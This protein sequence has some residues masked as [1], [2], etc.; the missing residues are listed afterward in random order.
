MLRTL[1]SCPVL[2]VFSPNSPGL[3]RT[4][5]LPIKPSVNTAL[6]PDLLLGSELVVRALAGV[7]ALTGE[8]GTTRWFPWYFGNAPSSTAQG[9]APPAFGVGD[10]Q[11]HLTLAGRHSCPEILPVSQGAQPDEEGSEPL[12]LGPAFT[13]GSRV[14]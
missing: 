10:E 3:S 9:P 1:P 13:V 11:Q 4:P 2:E 8:A 12:I 14:Q 7:C 5:Q 6:S